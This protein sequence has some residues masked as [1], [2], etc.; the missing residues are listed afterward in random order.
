MAAPT[1]AD[2]QTRTRI[3]D[4]AIEC[5]SQFGNDKT[6]LGDVATVAGLARQ[7]IYRYFPDR[8]SLL[9]A[10][11]NLEDRRLR[12]ETD[13]I[14]AEA[15][16]LEEFLMRFVAARAKTA[17]R[18]HTRQHLRARDRGLFQAMFLRQDRQTARIRELV[19][20]ALRAAR[21]RGELARRVDIEEAAE[22]IAIALTNVNTITDATTFDLDDPDAIGRFY[23][24][25]L[26][27]GVLSV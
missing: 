13:V 5:F 18:Y 1:S 8:A 3:L 2:E 10:V 21:R 27:R 16:S 12:D 23:A 22:W 11:D 26:C 19:T 17:V 25:Y 6:T 14:A 4:A 9:E 24:R 20:P 7:T 15:T